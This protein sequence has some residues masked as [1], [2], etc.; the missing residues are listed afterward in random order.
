MTGA[1]TNIVVLNDGTDDVVYAASTESKT[2]HRYQE[3]WSTFPVPSAIR[4][5]AATDNYL[6][7]M[8]HNTLY[9]YNDTTY[10]DSINP[11][12]GIL[13][14]VYAA[15]NWV[16]VG[17][18]PG[19]GPYSVDCYDDTLSDITS[20][21]SDPISGLL[22][23]VAEAG[24]NYFVATSG[25]G[26]G[27]YWIDSSNDVELVVTGQNVMGI[28]RVTNYIIAVT[29]SGTIYYFDHTGTIPVSPAP[30]QSYS[31][32]AASTGA[33]CSWNVTGNSSDPSTLLLVGVLGST[34][35]NSTTRGYREVPL[36]TAG[37]GEPTGNAKL[38]GSGSATTVTKTAKYTNSIGKHS[39]YSIRQAPN[40]SVIFASTYK[41]GLWALRDDE[42]N[43]EP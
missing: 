20:S 30:V 4:Q 36:D 13:Q 37:T 7:V 41:D 28:I 9:Q 25:A 43:G 29:D 10:N 12:G 19:L 18:G 22:R 14:S 40:S 16:F 3:G 15:N 2:V 31:L 42:W 26:G 33:M 35:S 39:I 8:G 6:Y 17:K 21:L 24:G 38:P 5:L 32:G 27:I 11:G 23:G 1:P 34:T